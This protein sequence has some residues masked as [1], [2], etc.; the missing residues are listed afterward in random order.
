[1]EENV[2]HFLRNT[3]LVSLYIYGQAVV[4]DNGLTIPPPEAGRYVPEPRRY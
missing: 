3:L 2:T 4:H 1:M